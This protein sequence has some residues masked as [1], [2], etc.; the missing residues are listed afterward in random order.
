MTDPALHLVVGQPEQ[1]EGDPAWLEWLISHIDPRWRSSEWDQSLFLFTGDL[2]SP[3]TAVWRCQTKGCPAPTRRHNGRCDSCRKERAESGLSEEA[4]D[5]QPRRR[6]ARSTAPGACSVAGCKGEMFCRG[7]CFVHERAWRRTGLPL[8][9]F[10]DRAEPLARRDPCAVA[11]CGRE[12][13][14]LRGLCH[15]HSQHLQYHQRLGDLGSLSGEQLAAWVAR[16]R[17]RLAAHQFSMASLPEL[18]RYELLYALQRRDETPPPLDPVQVWILMTRLAGTT[19]IRRADPE[20]I[21]ESGGRQYNGVIRGLFRDFRRYLDRAWVAHT[22][23]DPYAGDLWEVGL[24]DLQPNGSRHWPAR[25][26]VIDFGD[27]ELYWL[28]EVAKDWARTTRPYVQVLREV[29]RACRVASDVLIA[30]GR[31][32]PASLGAGDFTIVAKAMSGQRRADGALYSASHRNLLV[33]RLHEVIEHGRACGLMAE[34]PDPFGRGRQRRVAREENEEEIGK[35]IPESVIRQLDSN[36]GLLGPDCRGGSISAADLKAMYQAIYRL[37]RDTGRR[38]GEIVS[39]KFGSIEVIDDQHNLVY[40]NHKAGRMRRR[41]PI[42]AETAEILLTWEHRRLLIASPP[43]S[44]QWLFPTPLLRA[45]QSVGHITASAVARVFKLWTAKIEHI[46]SEVLGPSGDPRAFDP[47]LIFPYTLRHSYAQRHA[48]AGVPVDVLRELMDHVLIE[49]TMGY[50]RISLKRKQ[51]AIRAVG[52]LAVD[53]SGRPAPFANPLAWERASVSVPFGNCS[54]PSNVKA[55]G[56]SCP[57][58]FQCAGCGFYRPDPS[59][60][61][62]IEEHVF[63]LRADLETAR[64]IGAAGYVIAN[65]GEQ[66]KAFVKVAETMRKRLAN[67]GTEDRTEVEEASRLLRRARAARHIPIVASN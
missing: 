47:S 18:V 44:R 65:L 57:I 13:V 62:A 63:S 66:I 37:L 42:T 36:L 59:Y 8:E 33:Q 40:D 48:D 2:D 54:E 6:R 19:S 30:S 14:S 5:S 21:C 34:V 9:E 43:V 7:L 22:G 51:Q 20:T 45:R 3:R 27:I 46:D 52:S 50:Y 10:I 11:G 29:M 55:G 64:A 16:Q 38:P 32:D 24:L 58:R 15:F 39:L 23:L 41:L 56:S 17:P 53:A 60:L 49:T 26:G 25:H 35:A 4:F 28:R 31:S 12:Q 61:P 67:L 1:L